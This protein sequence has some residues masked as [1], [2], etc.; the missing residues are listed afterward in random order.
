MT[1]SARLWAGVSALLAVSLAIE[2]A[3]LAPLLRYSRPAVEAGQIWRLL[4][5]HVV[6]LGPTHL[7]LNALGLVLVAVVVG[8]HLRLRAWA[9][10][11]AACALAVSAGLWWLAPQV[12]W[13]VGLSGVLHG[14]LVAGATAALATARER[15]FALVVIGVIVAKLVWEQAFGPTPGTAELSGGPVVTQAHLFGAIGGV[16][17]G[18][19]VL[20]IRALRGHPPRTE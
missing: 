19:S 12:D 4:T 6:H 16:C 13:Y 3:G 5:G 17:A 8:H 11:A 10:S 7:G 18:V 9:A 1:A 20:T 14:L 15:V 2:V